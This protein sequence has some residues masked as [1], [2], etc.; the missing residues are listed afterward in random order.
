MWLVTNLGFFSI[1]QK[2]ADKANATL[3]IRAR[4]RSDL[5]RLRDSFLPGMS[6]IK[7]NAGTD[8][9]FRA[10][11]P[12]GEVAIALANIAMGIDYDNFKNEVAKQ[13]GKARASTYSKVWDALYKLQ[14]VPDLT[15]FF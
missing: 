2:P 4:V 9:R 13:Q 8:Y 11:A 6:A 10:T 5:E 1:V 14:D 3:T 12:K 15:G 7:E